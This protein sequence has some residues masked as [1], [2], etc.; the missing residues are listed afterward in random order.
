MA[1]VLGVSVSSS[2]LCFAR[3]AI[4]RGEAPIFLSE[5]RIEREQ[6]ELHIDGATVVV[7]SEQLKD[8][9]AGVPHDEVVAIFNTDRFICERTFFPFQDSAK[10]AQIAPLQLEEE[11]PFDLTGFIVDT[12][13]GEDSVDAEYPALIV[14]VPELEIETTLNVLKNLKLDPAII[15]P[16]VVGLSAL[17]KEESHSIVSVENGRFQFA[18]SVNGSPVILREKASRD[19]SGALSEILPSLLFAARTLGDSPTTLYSVGRKL[20]LPFDTVESRVLTPA[21]VSLGGAASLESWQAGLLGLAIARI[22]KTSVINF[23][24][25][26]FHYHGNY[27]Q[28]LAPLWEERKWFAILFVCL[29]LWFGSAFYAEHSKQSLLDSRAQ[30]VVR[31]VFPSELINK[32]DEARFVSEKVQGLEERLKGLGSVSALSPLDALKELS[33]I[34]T[35][36]VDLAIDS[37]TITPTAVT[38]GGTVSDTATV[39]RLIGIFEKKSDR[40]C[41]RKLDP[42]GN[43]PGSTRVRVVGELIYC[44]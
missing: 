6:L 34:I 20:V 16:G 21:T 23:R 41:S 2:K 15:A 26:K 13:V 39:G 44:L 8:Y 33:E 24:K 29:L 3:F 18:S 25:G 30:D 28:I 10:I 31:I 17:M 43:V 7:P 32:G 11:L 37:L 19:E 40:F 27:R 4:E 12:V 36:S 42:R 14:A 35:P 22:E 38:F 9:L 1:I 5:F